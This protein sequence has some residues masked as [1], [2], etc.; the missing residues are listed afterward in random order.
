MG[1]EEELELT[2][3]LAKDNFGKNNNA[4]LTEEE[5]ILAENTQLTE[6]EKN[7][8]LLGDVLN[9]P[10]QQIHPAEYTESGNL[11]SPSFNFDQILQNKKTE[12]STQKVKSAQAVFQRKEEILSA[13]NEQKQKAINTPVP[14]I[15][16]PEADVTDSLK[17]DIVVPSDAFDPKVYEDLVK[18]AETGGQKDPNTAKNP[19]STALGAFQITKSTWESLRIQHPEAGLTVDGRTD[20]E[21]SKKAHNLLVTDNIANLESKNIPVNYGNLYVMHTLGAGDGTT[22]LQAA[23][24]EDTGLAADLVPSRV[25]ESNPTWF[26]NNP[27]SQ[28]LVDLLAHKVKST[29]AQSEFITKEPV[30]NIPHVPSPVSTPELI[31]QDPLI[32]EEGSNRPGDIA[33]DVVDSKTRDLEFFT[34]QEQAA[35]KIGEKSGKSLNKQWGQLLDTLLETPDLIEQGLKNSVDS[36]QIV[37]GRFMESKNITGVSPN[38][39]VDYIQKNI[40]EFTDWIKQTERLEQDEIEKRTGKAYVQEFVGSKQARDKEVKDL[41]QKDNIEKVGGQGNANAIKKD[42]QIGIQAGIDELANKMDGALETGNNA[43]YEKLKQQSIELR[44]SKKEKIVQKATETTYIPIDKL[45]R[46]YLDEFPLHVSVDMD[47]GISREIET[48]AWDMMPSA[49]IQ[50]AGEGMM[51]LESLENKTPVVSTYGKNVFEHEDGG[52]SVQTHDGRVLNFNNEIDAKS[53]GDYN[54]ANAKGMHEGAPEAGSP[55]EYFNRTMEGL[56]MPIE[57]LGSAMT[58]KTLLIEKVEDWN[59]KEVMNGRA[60]ITDE[61]LEK[62]KNKELSITDPFHKT[63]IQ[64]DKEAEENRLQHDA[65]GVFAD[66]YRKYFPVNRKHMAGAA[67]AF[68]LIHEKR[69]RLDSLLY[70]FDNIGTFT[71]QGFDS[72]GFTLALTLGNVPVQLGMLAS[73]AKGQAN[74][75]IRDY[76]KQH[77]EEPSLEVIE[78]IKISAAFS[79]AAE[80][81]SMGYM[82]G[83]VKGLPIIGDQAKWVSKVGASINRSIDGNVAT[84]LMKRLVVKPGISILGEGI[85][86]RISQEAEHYGMTGKWL[87]PAE[88]TLSIVAGMTAAPGV[89][90]TLFALQVGSKIVGKIASPSQA[91]KQTEQWQK[92]L[93]VFT[94][95]AGQIDKHERLSDLDE[96]IENLSREVKPSVGAD[97]SGVETANDRFMFHYDQARINDIPHREAIAD[98]QRR[99]DKELKQLQQERTELAKDTPAIRIRDTVIAQPIR[100][101]IIEIDKLIAK[102]DNAQAIATLENTKKDLEAKLDAP[103][104]KEQLAFHKNTVLELKTAAERN[105]IVLD[106][107]ASKEDKEKAARNPLKSGEIAGLKQELSRLATVTSAILGPDLGDPITLTEEDTYTPEK[108]SGLKL[109]KQEGADGKIVSTVELISE[110]KEWLDDQG[111][112]LTKKDFTDPVALK[113]F[114][115]ET[116]EFDA[117]QKKGKAKLTE[118]RKKQAKLEPEQVTA[119]R[120][121]KI[122]EKLDELVGR[123]LNDKEKKEV[124][125]IIK[126]YEEK[127]ILEPEAEGVKSVSDKLFSGPDPFGDAQNATPEDLQKAINN[128]K[129]PK[130]KEYLEA[131]LQAQKDRKKQVESVHDKDFATVHA[132]IVSGESG[133]YTG[134][135]T[136]RDN[137][138][139]LYKNIDKLGKRA[140]QRKIQV[141]MDAMNVHSENLTS[142]LRAFKQAA[143]NNIDT[144]AGVGN[145]WVVK[146]N[147]A[148]NEDGSINTTSRAMTYSVQKM[149]EKEYTNQRE[150]EGKYLNRIDDG[151]VKLIRALQQEVSLGKSAVKAVNSYAGTSIEQNAQINSVRKSSARLFQVELGKI[152]TKIG[153]PIEE[154]TDEAIDNIGTKAKDTT[155]EAAPESEDTEGE[156]SPAAE[157]KRIKKEF[158]NTNDET[159]KESLRERILQLNE[160]VQES[161]SKSAESKD[162]GPEGKSDL[163][164]ETSESS[165]ASSESAEQ[166]TTEGSTTSDTKEKL[167]LTTE[168]IKN[169]IESAIKEYLPVV[170][171]ASAKNL[172]RM[173]GLLN[174]F[175]V[176][177]VQIGPTKDDL[178]IASLHTLTDDVF[179][180]EDGTVDVTSVT[181]A[182]VGLKI[183]SNGAA[184]LATMYKTFKAEYNKIAH[185]DL[186]KKGN[187]VNKFAIRQ[188]LSILLREYGDGVGKLPD[189]VLFGMMIGATNFRQR[190]LHNDRF[191]ADWEK[192]LFLYGGKDTV[193]TNKEEEQLKDLGY[194]YNETAE[195]IGRDVAALLRMTPKTVAKDS[196]I[197]QHG[198]DLY[199]DNLT[200][201][202]GMMALEIG[203]HTNLF[204]I[205][206]KIWKFNDGGVNTR[207]FN[208]DKANK[209]L[210]Y[211]HIK[212][213]PQPKNDIELAYKKGVDELVKVTKTQM[214]D[215]GFT[216]LQEPPK[217]SEDIKGTFGNIPEKV[218]TALRNLQKQKWN[219]AETLDSVVALEDHQNVLE[220][221][222][223]VVDLKGI[224]RH[225]S[226]TES[227]EAANR[228]KRTDLE[229]ILTAYDNDGEN[230]SLKDFYYKYELQNQHRILMRGRINPQQSKVTRFLLRSWEAQTYNAD[231][232]WK[233]KLAVAQ[234]FGIG[235]DKENLLFS[236]QAF[237]DIVENENVLIAV[238]ALR[239]IQE[240]QGNQKEEAKKLADALVLIKNTEDYKDSDL[241]LLNG[242]TA[243]TNYMPDGTPQTEFKSDVVM[244]VDGVSNGFAMNVM[245]FPMFDNLDQILNQIGNYF[246]VRSSHDTT[247]KDV[248]E[249]LG[250]HVTAGMTKEKAWDWYADNSWKDDFKDELF[251]EGD[252]GYDLKEPDKKIKFYTNKKGLKDW[253]ITKNKIAEKIIKA[254]YAKRNSALNNVFPNFL[255]TKSLRKLVKYPFLIHMYGGGIDRISTD[256]SKD[257]IKNIY[258][259]A[260]EIHRNYKGMKSSDPEVMEAMAKYGIN[261]LKEYEESALDDFV[262]SLSALGAFSPGK[263]VTTK[264][265]YKEALLAGKSLE[266]KNDT[267]TFAFND[268][269][270][271]KMISRTLTPRLEYGLDKMLKPT[272]KPRDTVIQMGEMLHEV[273][274][275]H[276]SRAYKRELNKINKEYKASLNAE[277][278]SNFNPLTKLTKKQITHLIKDVNGELI[279][280]FPQYEGPLSQ[281]AENESGEEY[282]EGAVDLS[283]MEF[284]KPNDEQTLDTVISEIVYDENGK[285]KT[286]ETFPSQLKF[287]EPGV[288]A[289]IRQIINMDSVILTQT[290]NGTNRKG[291]PRVTKGFTKLEWTGDTGLLMLH[292]AFMGSPEQLSTVSEIYG[293]IYLA[294]NL[295]HSVIEKTFNQLKKVIDLTEKLDVESGKDSYP[296]MQ[297]LNG[298]YMFKQLDRGVS[299]ERIKNIEEIVDEFEGVTTKV[300]EKREELKQRIKD[301]GMVSHQMYMPQQKDL[302]TSARSYYDFVMKSQ[303]EPAVKER[304]SQNSKSSKGVI[305]VKYVTKD[306]KSSVG[307]TRNV[308]A[309]TDYKND[310]I[311]INKAEVE[312]TFK[313]KAWKFPKM[314]GVIAFPENAFKTVEEWETF[315]IAHERAHFT[316]SNQKR[317]Q[318]FIREN[319]ANTEAYIAVK[320][321][322]IRYEREQ[323]RKA[324][325]PEKKAPQKDPEDWTWE[326]FTK[327]LTGSEKK[328]LNNLLS[329]PSF[330]EEQIVKWVNDPSLLLA[331]ITEQQK[332]E[333]DQDPDYFNED[334]A[335]DGSDQEDALI[336]DGKKEIYTII[337]NLQIKDETD[338]LL[339]LDNLPKYP[340]DDIE[341]LGDI[342]KNNIK[343]L[344]N[345]FKKLSHQHYSDKQEMDDHTQTLDTVLNVLNEGIAAVGG[346][347][348]TLQNIKGITQGEYDIASNAMGMFLSNDAPFSNNS[349]S[350]QE[351]YVHELLHATTALAIRENPLVAKR[352]ER[353]YDQT[354]DALN[355]KYGENLGY[356]VF[357][358]KGIRPSNNDIEMAKLQYNYIFKGKEKAK[359]HEFLAYAVTNKQMIDFLKTQPKVVRAGVLGKLLDM[360]TL[361]I[362]VIKESFGARTYR[363]TTGNAF[364]DMLAATEHL[365]A[366]QAKHQSS[367]QQLS[368]KLYAKADD[369]DEFLKQFAED[370][371]VRVAGDPDKRQSKFRKGTRIITGGLNTIFGESEGARKA[372]HQVDKIMSKTLRGIAGE[373]GSGVLTQDMIEQLL[374]VKVNI[375]KARQQ[376]ETFTNKWFNGDPDENIKGIWKSTDPLNKHAMPIK[377]KIALTEI[378]LRTDLSAL[379][380]KGTE[381]ELSHKEIMDLI[382]KDTQTA[383]KRKAMQSGI[384]RKLKLH[385]SHKAIAYAN[386]LGHHIVTNKTRLNRANMNA[387][388]IALDYLQNPTPEQ[389]ALLDTY[390]TLSALNYTDSTQDNLVTALSNN[391]F[392]KD[393]KENGMTELI[394]YH[395]EY[396]KDSKK[397]LF[398]GNATQMVKGYI[399][400]RV[401]NFTHIKVGPKSDMKKMKDLGYTE[402]YD[403]TKV[404]PNQT[405]DTL[406]ITRTIPEVND[407]S[408]VMSTTNQRNMGTTLTEIF[409]RDPAFQIDG[410]PDFFNINIKVKKFIA[411]QEI[412]AKNVQW[413]ENLTLRPVFD[414]NNVITDYRVMMD[415]TWKTELLRP[416]LEYQNVFAHMRSAAIDR[417]ETIESDKKTVE[418]LVYEQEDMM[419]AYPD[420]KW[421]DIMD[422]NSPYIDR[423]RKLPR[424]VRDLI[425]EYALDGKFM[426]REDVVDKVFGYKAFD[427]S[428][429]KM[430]QGEDTKTKRITKRVAGITHHVI[431]QTVGYGKNRIVIAMPQV[432]VGNMMSNVYQLLMRKIPIDFIF[433]KIFE[434]I[435]EYNKYNKDTKERTKLKAAINA[436]GLD[437]KNSDEAI[438]VAR[439]NDRIQG[440][441]IHRMSSAGLNSL[442]VEDINDSQTDGYLNKLRK[443]I[444]ISFPGAQKYIDNVPSILGDAAALL[445]MT[446]NSKPYQISRHIVQMTDFLGRYVMIE[447]ATKVKG[448]DFKTAMHEA[449][450]AFVLF[451]EALV[452]ALEAVDAVGATSFLS[453]Y[454]RNARSSKQL[455]QTSPTGVAMSAAFQ[456]VTGI[457]TLGNVNSS[458]L[459][460]KFSPNYL[461][462]DELFDEANNVTLFDVVMNDGRNLFN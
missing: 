69:G 9:R 251:K 399:V 127:G 224:D 215:Y 232:I 159:R 105:L 39:V 156:E 280:V 351:V 125:G 411:K 101:Q 453:Y 307:S 290:L 301:E 298:I 423:Y 255:N 374:H 72:I 44:K 157:L 47:V 237:D 432:V 51:K 288:S 417:K 118:L 178:K 133:N 55:H 294:Y 62:Y 372:R 455:V 52:W 70:A 393:S 355:S 73:L 356:K 46:D 35:F 177:L 289:L 369:S 461:Q 179:L 304:Q 54:A 231:N 327:E 169:F 89:G 238:K 229:E 153:V 103:L 40:E 317:P 21:Q 385:N 265:A 281:I 185:K 454:L 262:N 130:T 151:S 390:A 387:T 436:K 277:D 353:L 124:L 276:Y 449:L 1:K 366:I 407:V 182:L 359:L 26:Q 128:E 458:W 213:I 404:D 348:L 309:Q 43:L 80:K 259:K 167:K 119:F 97:G 285:K 18:A 323:K 347:K 379:R 142:K 367:Y 428:Q 14:A 149:S 94:M 41:I 270:L 29:T 23:M 272:K 136:Y 400:E 10:N 82:K 426:I 283:N 27:T 74:K 166:T 11:P 219:T 32:I 59:K 110:P 60:P 459:G 207:N 321:L 75:M 350:P 28:E 180:K 131:T 324:P 61:I 57:L 49:E 278:K 284:S 328:T 81:I 138:I 412:A 211:R 386:E 8:V 341:K 310:Q 300:L 112:R 205:E 302:I 340:T 398:N 34:E 361:V 274:M 228:D 86:E 299:D 354:E 25:V 202:F 312:R 440:N 192:S 425:K 258:E 99:V 395:L 79:L 264:E 373:I 451:D 122:L 450:D 220:Q 263:G 419:E 58:G 329:I 161:K 375:S 346:I 71:E 343:K 38:Q 389:I 216:P 145:I 349:Q 297:E 234:N 311:L 191:S 172:D 456:Q 267:A 256:V 132:D 186:D 445:F 53:Y 68:K 12:I 45:D 31:P 409:M 315:L 286:R 442:I 357:L 370:M 7:Q 252:T 158:E 429:L 257:V 291:D 381:F 36:L 50:A 424:E 244:E 22:I 435:S 338:S 380:N 233:F 146:G 402:S 67:T 37:A 384:V 223:G 439:L 269:A 247:Q 336:N 342:T 303:V 114:L 414:E 24:N 394:D 352:I 248:Y 403:L 197:T 120:T 430:L 314:E 108:G 210:G 378:M 190:T 239:N 249:T 168:V 64:L 171:E 279:Q 325:T 111:R 332:E 65:I 203:Q 273:F 176:D 333:E 358:T 441:L 155:E 187:P 160:I 193:L 293:K 164:N 206:K 63:L 195:K 123:D 313:E 260:G 212:V 401:D 95:Q 139:K 318:G 144:P 115:N 434:G 165:D 13:V 241:S 214:E 452:P 225:Q 360:V 90:G 316:A 292:D 48:A 308:A 150:T 106:P 397:D 174:A 287:I 107:K 365:V 420:M 447:H 78:R 183:S 93:S 199:F 91:K 83:V 84:S 319:H 221:L 416:D 163:P 444:P 117:N 218:K 4:E 104:N 266:F 413:D 196:K 92:N 339:T 19:N 421:I 181:A 226:E 201:A 320:Q 200:N 209:G 100:Q 275:L 235:V 418:L 143:S 85:Q 462:S 431:K 240:K 410:K 254:R 446:K 376:S 362:N 135:H 148:T 422:P 388:S 129:D 184:S 230:N 457:P 154:I 337:T 438:K 322:R 116:K 330:N 245:Q 42:D 437:P 363:D 236:E 66:S 427:L 98:A 126:E 406:Y 326:S 189:Q 382:G 170:K 188:P 3:K 305:P 460:G 368:A 204:T 5:R 227:I 20:P 77:G 6:D 392:V 134:L 76:V 377:T 334:A 109:V 141:Q 405:Y 198:V 175:F 88:G 33:N 331:D 344:F 87:D 335:Y 282:I 345:R 56:M 408:G 2:L 121:A 268:A 250:G 102:G 296:L 217:L 364:N 443:S 137:I 113:K 271:T 16:L 194:G 140:Q 295:K 173:L 391:E 242:I 448:Q 208:D 261:T 371:A 253:Q 243:L 15:E 396:K 96:Q 222:M 415:N 383:N 17:E 147:R 433:H 306:I 152:K 246:D 162:A 30:A